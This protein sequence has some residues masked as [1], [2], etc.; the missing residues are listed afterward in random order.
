MPT[1]AALSWWHDARFGMFIHWGLYALLARHEWTM[2]Q[3]SIPPEEYRG[4]AD[5]FNPQ[6][7][8]P[9]EWVALAQD[10]GMR[11]MIL[12]S[13]H[14]EGFSLWDSK[15]SDFT[16]PKTAARR[17]LLAEF[18]NACEKR[19]MRY[20]FYYSLLDWRYPAYFRGKARDPEGWAEFL[21]YVHAQVLELCTN[22]GDLSVLWYDGG[23]PYTPEDWGSTPLNAEVRRLRPDI[24]INN[25][26]MQPEDFDTPEQHV[27][28][29][30]DRLWESC[31]TMNTTWGYS[32]I[33]REWKSPR[34]LIHY[35]VTAAN[36]GGNYLLNVGPDPDG[37]IPFESVERL[38]AMGRW[39]DVYGESIYGSEPPP[40]G[41]ASAARAERTRRSATRSTCTAGA[42]RAR[43]SWSAASGDASS[44]RAC[45]VPT[46]RSPWSNADTASGCAACRPTPLIPSI[47]LSRWSSTARPKNTTA[48]AT[49]RECDQRLNPALSQPRT[50]RRQ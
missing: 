13:R 21:D 29:S 9:E 7:Y 5:R 48:S 6:H 15:V 31:M 12:T 23:W 25:R 27:T 33:D 36:G 28:P 49:S 39:L 24:L 16:A 17:D 14:H 20:G 35:L 43:R 41:C 8:N 26:S 19:G 47:R 30:P 38:R 34:Q 4:L 3:E 40:T 32:T 10:A 42:G 2:Y 45:W 18:V 1:P 44:A 46:S 37:R 11:Y 50:A 22:Y